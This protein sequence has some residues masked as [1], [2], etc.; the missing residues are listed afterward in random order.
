MQIE[1]LLKLIDRCNKQERRYISHYLKQMDKSKGKRYYKHF[2]SIQRKTRL[3]I[4]RQESRHLFRQVVRL[5]LNYKKPLNATPS[6]R[7]VLEIGKVFYE[8]G[9]LQEAYKTL[10]KEIPKLERRQKW[11]EIVEFSELLIRL[12]RL[13]YF[14]NPKKL[15]QYITLQEK[16]INIMLLQNKFNYYSSLI[17]YTFFQEG[18]SRVPEVRKKLYE[19]LK[20][21]VLQKPPPYD[22]L[23]CD[24]QY[25]NINGIGYAFLTEFQ[26]SNAYF[27]ELLEVLKKKYTDT[28]GREKIELITY[29]NL[30]NNYLSLDAPLLFKKNAEQ[31]IEIFIRYPIYIKSYF[32]TAFFGVLTG[33]YT[34]NFSEDKLREILRVFERYQGQFQESEFLKSYKEWVLTASI[35]FFVLEEY[36]KSLQYIQEFKTLNVPERRD[37]SLLA[38]LLTLMTLY[39]QKQ[40]SLLRAHIRKLKYKL[41]RM[42]FKNY[43]L[44]KLFLQAL[45]K[46]GD[47]PLSEHTLIFHETYHKLSA[48]Y[49]EDPAQKTYL[50]TLPIEEWLQAKI[51]GKNFQTL[52][53]SEKKYDLENWDVFMPMLSEILEGINEE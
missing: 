41:K 33:F 14:D 51:Y 26:K 24:A 19:I 11:N 28:Q 18:F 7:E 2:I 21:E 4:T 45:K 52:L 27:K 30:C 32:L 5:L 20:A 43:P 25:Y 40:Y 15:A 37:L 31:S 49:K 50:F 53:I 13:L 42:E 44:E 46:S 12:T 38:S 3:T 8:K 36:D 48:L 17:G 10:I 16:A 39:E 22:D 1:T 29:I 34:R 35:A 6:S 47:L 23:L 9:M